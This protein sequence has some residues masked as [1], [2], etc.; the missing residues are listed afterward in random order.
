[1]STTTIRRRFKVGGVLTNADAAVF[2]SPDGTYGI[3]RRDTLA[4]VVASGVALTNPSTGLYSYTFTDP[5]SRLVY[6]FYIK[7]TDGV[8]DHYIQGTIAGGRDGNLYGLIPSIAPYVGGVPDPVMKQQLRECAK[9]YFQKTGQWRETLDLVGVTDQ[10]DYDLTAVHDHDADI[11]RVRAV[12][13]VEMPW[14]FTVDSTTDT[15]TMDPAP[16]EDDKEAI[17]AAVTFLPRDTNDT[18]P[19]ELLSRARQ[20][21]VAGT[22]SRLYAM[23]KKPWSDM[24]A[25]QTQYA[26]YRELCGEGKREFTTGRGDANTRVRGRRFV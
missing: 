10:A 12:E 24:Q 23:S 8:E 15:L 18:Y 26:I 1:M 19:E 11:L 22:K 9:E 17:T 2:A 16:I 13:K 7:F 21:I 4:V 3:R 5:A 14:A 20:A 6:E 25:S